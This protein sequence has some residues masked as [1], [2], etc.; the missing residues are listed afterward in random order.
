ML[1]HIKAKGKL[2]LDSGAIA[3]LV[4]YNKSLLPVGIVKIDGRFDRGDLVV[5]MTE[6]G[7]EVAR[8]LIN[9]SSLEAEK[10]SGLL[11][12]QIEKELGY[13]EEPEV[14]HKDNLILISSS[15]EDSNTIGANSS[16]AEQ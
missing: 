13:M 9:Y 1:N 12:E 16:K 15:F 3:A 4:Q 10:I 8:G 7:V 6:K 14:I 5:C 2:Y 11:S